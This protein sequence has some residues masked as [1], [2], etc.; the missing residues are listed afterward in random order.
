MQGS[1]QNL[2]NSVDLAVSSQLGAVPSKWL[3]DPRHSKLVTYW[4]ATVGL[5]LLY[6]AIVT[7][8]EVGFLASFTAPTEPL[9]I[10]NQVILLLFVID[11]VM[12]FFLMYPE[13]GQHG[14]RYVYDSAAIARHYLKSW[15]L[16]DMICI[17]VSGFDYIFLGQD[18]SQGDSSYDNLKESSSTRAPSILPNPAAPTP[19]PTRLRASAALPDDP[20]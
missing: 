15:F 3:I 4:D 18:T 13:Q 7:P 19:Q 8:V 10:I 16:L 12:Q 11:M 14:S 6:T 1:A 2:F 9:F 20:C 17:G 5:A